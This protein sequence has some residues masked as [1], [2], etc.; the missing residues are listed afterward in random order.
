MK[1][2]LFISLLFFT[3]LLPVARKTSA[4]LA[5]L[6]LT[7][8]PSIQDVEVTPGKRTRTQI[9]FRNRGT[10][11]I[12]GRIKAADYIINDKD[13]TPVI[14]D[15]PGITPKYAA[16]SWIS[17]SYSNMTIAPNDFVTVDIFITPPA[18][19]NT[20]GRYA[21]VYFETQPLAPRIGQLNTQSAPLISTKLGAL[22]NFRVNRGAC[23]EGLRLLRFN[24]PSFLEYGPISVGFDLF[25]SGDYH[26]SPE[27]RLSLVN[28][29]GK[30]VAEQPLTDLRIFPETSRAYS[31][32]IGQKWML[33]KYSLGLLTQVGKNGP[34]V[35]KTVPVIIFPWKLALAFILA[36]AILV[37]IVRSFYKQTALK[38][39]LLE[40][41]VLKDQSEIEKL[42][43]ELRRR[44]E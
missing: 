23:Q 7:A 10:S 15:D 39:E 2:K 25:N 3:L 22:L 1:K 30:T 12:S 41:E 19:I 16:A 11:F 31:A 8:Y 32:T 37:L 29:F 40:K 42:K 9:Q 18:E 24:A 27:G 35:A 6:P 34:L 20:C 33:G 44:K 4:Q 13:G 14:I 36:A 21:I 5:E 43:E 26:I 38:E 17:T 28:L